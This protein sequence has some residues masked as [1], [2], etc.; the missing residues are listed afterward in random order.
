MILLAGVLIVL[1]FFLY[2]TQSTVISSIGQEAGRE[3][4]NPLLSD[5]QGLRSSVAQQ[6]KYELWNATSVPICPTDEAD[7]RGKV[8]AKLVLLSK[9][10]SNRGQIFMGNFLDANIP[11]PNTSEL[12]TQIKMYLTNGRATVT[13]TATFVTTCT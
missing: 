6:L 3:A 7:F 4:A 5:Y 11:V 1:A 12:E 8:Q 13:D 9:L 10:E 2:S